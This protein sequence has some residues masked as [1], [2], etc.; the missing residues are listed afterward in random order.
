MSA[1]TTDASNVRG[2]LAT[3]VEAYRRYMDANPDARVLGAPIIEEFVLEH[4]QAYGPR[5]DLP[6]D[7]EHGFAQECFSNAF[8]HAYIPDSAYTYVEGYAHTPSFPIPV[9][10][11]WIVTE[12]GEVIDPT[13]RDGGHDCAFCL[14]T[15]IRHED[16]ICEGCDSSC[17]SDCTK[18]VAC[19]WCEG[20]GRDKDGHPSREGTHY[21][22]VPVPPELLTKTVIAK[23][24]YGVLDCEKARKAL[25]A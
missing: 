10:H 4:G 20:T 9:H 6:D 21:F 24:S 11:A 22:G 14:N 7:V 8:N 5:I 3:L 25:A 16:V 1:T 23:G 2:F 13:W 19:F 17:G 15:G 18:E 12:R